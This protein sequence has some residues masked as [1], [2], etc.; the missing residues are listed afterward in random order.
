VSDF[1]V[2]QLVGDRNYE[3][4]RAAWP[5]RPF[6]VHGPLPAELEAVA[7]LFEMPEAVHRLMIGSDAQVTFLD[8]PRPA[9]PERA[10]AE[11]ERG[12][13]LY[14]VR[15]DRLP[16]LG[17]LC[18][19][20]ARSL[21]LQP[22]D[23][24]CEG[25]AARAGGRAHAHF[26]FEL[27]FNIQLRGR[28]T[29]RIAE[30]KDIVNPLRS[31]HTRAEKN[32]GFPFGKNPFTG[33]ELP[34]SM[35]A[36][37]RV[38]EVEPGSVVFVP[39][40]FWH[41][42]VST[43]DSVAISLVVKPPMWFE[44]V[45]RVLE[46]EL[47]QDSRWREYILDGWGTA[48][49][50]PSLGADYGP[51]LQEFLGKVVN[52]SSRDVWAR[53]AALEVAKAP[54][55]EPI[56][57]EDRTAGPVSPLNVPRSSDEDACRVRSA[58]RSSVRESGRERSVVDATGAYFEELGSRVQDLW[59]AK[60]FD[61]R[62]FP[63]VAMKALEEMPPRERTNHV[64]IA[65]HGL[66]A[67]AI[68]RQHDLEAT[69]G[70]PPLTL[71]HGQDF[72]VEALFWI[73]GL[74]SIHQHSFSGAFHVLEGSSIHCEYT[75]AQRERINARM[76]LGDVT[77][78]GAELLKAGDSRPIPGGRQFAH[79]TYHMD[80]PT[81]TIV[82]RTV[83]EPENRPQYT[84]RRPCLALA[85]QEMQ[86][87]T[88]RRLQLLRMLH[89]ANQAEHDDLSCHLITQSDI[90][91]TFLV[92]EQYFQIIQDD[93][94]RERVVAA[95]RLKHGRI[96]DEVVLPVLAEDDRIRLVRTRVTSPEHSFLRSLL[97]NVPDR[98]SILK[99]VRERHPARDAV[100][101]LLELIGGFL[102]DETTGK[103]RNGAG[104]DDVSRRMVRGLLE[105]RRIEE[106]LADFREVYG[107][108]QVVRHEAAIREFVAALR[109][110][111]LLAPLFS[112]P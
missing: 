51:L 16:L 111:K 18:R 57:Q 2:R 105:G 100:E 61:E 58:R 102:V 11:Y 80:R 78:K 22:K 10:L 96:V 50:P 68:P 87:R 88:M 70:E 85:P 74:V 92:L 37:A 4:F 90:L 34:R 29:W 60:H 33:A 47:S 106:T 110:S 104:L 31:F 39:R 67:T 79:A 64:D 8:A 15:L 99:I 82:V 3:A 38:I 77:L 76:L 95:A 7:A 9:S 52:L 1:G 55:P 48:E 72:H 86:A 46:S 101:V 75:F 53:Y 97:L 24:Q 14:L 49:G 28:K 93:G 89:R 66:L 63:E 65:R 42:T 30:N 23:V 43:T 98:P 35:P 73:D 56:R 36:D 59:L 54:S 45:L 41:E 71:F 17:E 5:S 32:R 6:E 112:S 91:T 84:Y 21:Q 19:S 103:S 40:G 109:R 94:R 81:V 27:N 25:F 69:F 108:D 20:F 13:A 62:A 44:V 107:S 12:R 26:D 83:S